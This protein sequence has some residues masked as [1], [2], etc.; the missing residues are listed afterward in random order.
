M[1]TDTVAL[2]VSLNKV[3]RVDIISG[4][5]SAKYNLLFL[6]RKPIR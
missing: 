3:I 6:K 4:A 2:S 5:S 1:L